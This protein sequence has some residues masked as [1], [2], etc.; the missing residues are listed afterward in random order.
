MPHAGT[1]V[2]ACLISGVSAALILASGPSYTESRSPQGTPYN[3]NGGRSTY[4]GCRAGPCQIAYLNSVE[5]F[6]LW[7][8]SHPVLSATS[9]T[10]HTLVAWCTESAQGSLVIPDGTI[11]GAH[12]VITPEYVQITGVGKLTNINVPPDGVVSASGQGYSDHRIVVTSVFGQLEQIS[13]WTIHDIFGCSESVSGHYDTGVFED[14]IVDG[15]ESQHVSV[16]LHGANDNGHHDD[17]DDFLVVSD[18]DFECYQL[19]ELYHSP[20]PRTASSLNDSP[21]MSLAPSSP[22]PST[23]SFIS[24]F[25]SSGPL[26]GTATPFATSASTP[27]PTPSLPS[28]S[29]GTSSSLPGPPT[30]PSSYGSS[31]SSSVS[32]AMSSSVSSSISSQSSYIL[33]FTNPSLLPFPTTSPATSSSTSYVLTFTTHSLSSV[34]TTPPASSPSPVSPSTSSSTSAQ[35][36]YVLPSTTPSSSD[37]T[38]SPAPSSPTVPNS[39]TQIGPQCPP[40]WNAGTVSSIPLPP[41]TLAILMIVISS[42]VGIVVF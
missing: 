24:T 37:P 4:D 41:L 28:S 10:E 35:T 40:L 22:I 29:Y 11:L 7:A 36:S 9:S 2:L 30:P 38:A 18:V 19:Y 16:V 23:P 3:V 26:A 1:Y 5:D 25:H 6:C 13:E 17:P 14:C 20:S 31:T 27:L 42:S 34:P 15:A 21:S 32:S 12:L 39:Q 33:T 8:P